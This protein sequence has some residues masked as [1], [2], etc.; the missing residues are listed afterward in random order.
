[1][2]PSP[3]PSLAF[4][5]PSVGAALVLALAGLACA[6]K[7][8]VVKNHCPIPLWSHAIGW[9][10]FG[11]AALA[12]DGGTPRRI[13]PGESFTYHDLPLVGGGRL[14]AYYQDPGAESN[15]T[16]AVSDHN[17]FVE[18]TIDADA[19]NYNISY[20]DHA[21]LPV[22][23]KASG[24]CGETKVPRT[25]EQ[26]AKALDRCPTE[27]VHRANG[28]GVCLASYDYCIR[29][30]RD[31]TDPYCTKMQ[32]YG[33]SGTQIYGG[34]FPAMG[35]ESRD[36]WDKVAAWNRG[37]R[38][39][40]ADS[41]LYYRSDSVPYN[42]YAKWVHQ[43]LAAE[44]YGFST[45]D[46]QD[47]SGFQRCLQS[48]ELV[49]DWCAENAN[50]DSPRASDTTS[51]ASDS[52][53]SAKDPDSV[54]QNRDAK[55]P[56]LPDRSR[57]EPYP[58]TLVNATN[59]PRTAPLQPAIEVLRSNRD[60]K[61]PNHRQWLDPQGRLADST[62]RIGI[63]LQ[64]SRSF[65]HGWLWIYDAQGVFVAG[66]PIPPLSDREGSVDLWIAW[67][68]RTAS[69]RAAATGV[70]LFRVALITEDS[71]HPVQQSVWKLGWK[72]RP[73]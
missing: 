38:P 60:A 54:R 31:R 23:V 33:F 71:A 68:G 11:S 3:F 45:D 19:M 22:S 51:N 12:L 72:S 40:E 34:V 52:S 67:N 58:K 65:D 62:G 47:H 49:V 1:M 50:P 27:V 6:D 42:S 46:H 28:T 73:E 4:T 44:V 8:Y 57:M 59:P 13:A 56:I 64:G 36:F 7:R 55:T 32:A 37:T 10:R 66:K 14:Y 43:D 18:M 20:V 69:G 2:N 70:Y 48:D 30:D 25:F 16:R 15:T 41:S 24:A 53:T 63:L 9:E 29:A 35:S 21:S 61:F 39:G 5:H 17:Q 26:F